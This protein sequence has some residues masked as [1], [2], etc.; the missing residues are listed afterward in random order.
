MQYDVKTPAEYINSLDNDWRREKLES[1][2]VLIKSKAPQAVE[3][4]NYKMLSYSDSRGVIF[5][6]NAQKNYVSL[7]VG[8]ASKIDPDGNLLKGLERGKGC[9]RFK[10]YVLITDTRIDEFIERAIELWKRNADIN[11]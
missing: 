5:H 8:N 9:I 6:L 7:Y 11:C 2:R 10:K 4:I 1:L 3:G